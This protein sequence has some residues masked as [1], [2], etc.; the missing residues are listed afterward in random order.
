MIR[1]QPPAVPP[2]WVAGCSFEPQGLVE[3]W[4]T[5]DGRPAL[6]CDE[7]GLVWS[8]PEH[9]DVGSSYL[10]PA[11]TLQLADGDS[12]DP[13]GA[14]PAT[15]ADLERVGWWPHVAQASRAQ[16]GDELITLPGDVD[17]ATF[18]ADDRDHTAALTL[19]AA[20]ARRGVLRFGWVR[21]AD[22]ATADPDDPVGVFER[23]GSDLLR[24]VSAASPSSA[25]ARHFHVRVGDL[26]AD[27]VAAT[28]DLDLDGA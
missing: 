26:A 11:G 25:A 5:R 6:V 16:H 3:A 2:Y 8:D 12:L 14:R 20:G 22:T 23:P 15:R 24:R 10:P 17:G 13:A 1:R 28:M 27:I 4:I 19:R 18:T 21:H 9:L 7:C